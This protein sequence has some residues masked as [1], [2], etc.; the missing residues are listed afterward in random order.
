MC[1]IEFAVSRARGISSSFASWREREI[2]VGKLAQWTH[3][4]SKFVRIIGHLFFLRET[5]EQGQ[6]CLLASGDAVLLLQSKMSVLN[7]REEVDCGEGK[8]Y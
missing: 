5:A 7:V 6:I 2:V 4:I 1:G 3:R 8:V